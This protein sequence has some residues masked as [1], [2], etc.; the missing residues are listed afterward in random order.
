MKNAPIVK[1]I[2]LGVG[3]NDPLP[4]FF[5]HFPYDPDRYQFVP[6]LLPPHPVFHQLMTPYKPFKLFNGS[7]GSL[8][9]RQLM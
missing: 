1:L 4:P 5:R 6:F 8:G 2:L 7:F 3:F 9:R